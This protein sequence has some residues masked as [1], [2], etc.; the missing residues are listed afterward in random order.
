VDEARQ[1]GPSK[2]S[3]VLCID[4]LRARHPVNAPERN[5]PWQ[6]PTSFA[7]VST[8]EQEALIQRDFDRIAARETESRFFE[9]ACARL[10]EGLPQ[11]WKDAV[12]DEHFDIG[13]T[14][15]ARDIERYLDALADPTSNRINLLLTGPPGAG[16]TYAMHAV[17]IAAVNRRAVRPYGILRGTEAEIVRPLGTGLPSEQVAAANALLPGKV[18][19]IMVDDVGKGFIPT[20]IDRANYAWDILV[21]FAYEND[22]PIILTTNLPPPAPTNM[23]VL[24][25]AADRR[26]FEEPRQRNPARLDGPWGSTRVDEYFTTTA[27]DRLIKHT[28]SDGVTLLVDQNKRSAVRDGEIPR[29]APGRH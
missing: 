7:Q 19:M 27:W 20:E 21:N 26:A 18:A 24:A 15:A 2:A 9:A 28:V 11:R 6:W 14:G 17:A 25:G 1:L 29:P 23:P 22:V 8:S 5:E 10:E 12:L 4:C 3:C 13:G 16:K